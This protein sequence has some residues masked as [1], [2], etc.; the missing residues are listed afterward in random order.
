LALEFDAFW[1]VGDV[2][3]SLTP[4]QRS[5]I[6]AVGA[7]LTAM[8][9]GGPRFEDAVWTDNG[10]RTHAAWCE[11]RLAARA[12]LRALGHEPLAPPE[13]P[14]WR[15]TGPGTFETPDGGVYVR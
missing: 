14:L 13:R 8:S 15:Q 1:P 9:R 10:L 11:V 3:S 4:A 6:D 12:A 2:P 7:L 5:A